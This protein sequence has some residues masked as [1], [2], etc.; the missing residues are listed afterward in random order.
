MGANWFTSGAST[1]FCGHIP[2]FC[3]VVERLF[4]NK[5]PELD[6]DDRFAVYMGHSPNGSSVKAML[7]YA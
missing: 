7:H 5:H 3:E 1:L 4:V 6:D 2:E